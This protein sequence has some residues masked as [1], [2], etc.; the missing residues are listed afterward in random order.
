MTAELHLQQI[1]IPSAELESNTTQKKNKT[2]NEKGT[3]TL[4][5]IQTQG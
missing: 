4:L 2:V 5:K 3:F 1:S